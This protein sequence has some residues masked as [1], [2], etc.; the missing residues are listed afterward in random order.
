MGTS[1][2]EIAGVVELNGRVKWKIIERNIYNYN[3]YDYS[4]AF[5][6]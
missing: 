1:H 5:I 3:N 2:L 4:V 6:N